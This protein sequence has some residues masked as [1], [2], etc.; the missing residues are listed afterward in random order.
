MVANLGQA[1][2]T[3]Q[4]LKQVDGLASVIFKLTIENIVWES[5]ILIAMTLI[6][7]L[8]SIMFDCTDTDKNSY[9]FLPAKKHSKRTEILR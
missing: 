6:N 1:Y 9:I 2:E 8:N 3:L 7:R 5:N 4:D